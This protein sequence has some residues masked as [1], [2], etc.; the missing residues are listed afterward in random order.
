MTDKNHGKVDPIK[1]FDQKTLNSNLNAISLYITAFELLKTSVIDAVTNIL[2][3]LPDD[4]EQQRL[5]AVETGIPYDQRYERGMVPCANWLKRGEVITEMDVDNLRL[6][7][8]HRNDLV[9]ELPK[10]L[11]YSG[12]DVQHLLLQQARNLIM[13][14]DVWSA[15]NDVLFSLSG[16]EE[17]D[18]TEI[19]DTEIKSGR[20]IILDYIIS[21]VIA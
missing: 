10:Y 20:L 6:I 19:P 12:A 5:F 16:Y 7:R 14:I 3:W 15:R 17:I 1:L 13:K 18:I 9:H 2:V 11:I 4:L 21:K 8:S